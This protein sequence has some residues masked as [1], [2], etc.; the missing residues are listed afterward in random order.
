MGPPQ[1]QFL[2][3]LFSG[4]PDIVSWPGK[5][6]AR[7]TLSNDALAVDNSVHHNFCFIHLQCQRPLIKWL[8]NHHHLQSIYTTTDLCRLQQ[9]HSAQSFPPWA[10]EDRLHQEVAQ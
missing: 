3:V 2:F 4:P 8:A 1:H 5:M 9:P 7:L 6:H 10:V